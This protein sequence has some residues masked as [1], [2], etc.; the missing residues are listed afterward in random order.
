VK[1]Y[2]RDTERREIRA[3]RRYTPLAGARVLDIGCGDGRL[4]RKIARI[5]RL[6]VGVDP[7]AAAITRAKRLTPRRLRAKIR[8]HVGAAERLRLT[9]RRFD[10]ALFAGSL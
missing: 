10:I 3:L 9:G 1:G 4:A 6:V 8:Y 7:N 2:R 5:A